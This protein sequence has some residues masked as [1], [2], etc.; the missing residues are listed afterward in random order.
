[1]AS[2]IEGL[3]PEGRLVN[4]ESASLMYCRSGIS[5]VGIDSGVRVSAPAHDVQVGT[6]SKVGRE[7][8][9]TGETDAICG[10]K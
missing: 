4:V 6:G 7:C 2:G 9:P 10:T 5:C 8:D 3:E 1:M